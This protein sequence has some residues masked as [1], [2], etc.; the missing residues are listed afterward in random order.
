MSGLSG[1]TNLTSSIIQYVIFL[2]T[3][4]LMLPFIDRIGRRQLLIGGAII[5]M[6]LHFSKTHSSPL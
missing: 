2:V 6:I 3:T 4:G 1:N 5:C